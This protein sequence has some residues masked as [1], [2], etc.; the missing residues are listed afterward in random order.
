MS[1]LTLA[2]YLEGNYQA[3]ASDPRM[4]VPFTRDVWLRSHTEERY[5]N[6][7]VIRVGNWQRME[8]VDA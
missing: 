4:V 8:D 2:T 7:R 1:D 6:G 3:Y 5:H